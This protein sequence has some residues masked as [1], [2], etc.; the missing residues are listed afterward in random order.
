MI[1]C[2][3]NGKKCDGVCKEKNLDRPRSL[4]DK[5]GVRYLK[6]CPAAF[7]VDANG[8]EIREVN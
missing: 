7:E 5:Q 3:C 4:V 6:R 1:N 2:G 8:N